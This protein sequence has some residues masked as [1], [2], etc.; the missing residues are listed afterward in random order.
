[1]RELIRVRAGKVGL[2]V[3]LITLV[4]VH[5]W[6][7]WSTS[8]PATREW[9]NIV[10][11]YAGEQQPIRLPTTHHSVWCAGLVHTD[12]TQPR[13]LQAGELHD[14]HID[15]QDRAGHRK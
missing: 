8:S 4:L 1:M 12:R 11:R 2:A 10:S 5:R 14:K 3:R 6:P 13:N 9:V 15:G 7:V